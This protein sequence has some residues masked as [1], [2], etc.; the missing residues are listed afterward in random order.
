MPVVIAAKCHPPQFVTP[1]K[2]RRKPFILGVAPLSWSKY[3]AVRANPLFS[4]KDF[5]GAGW[6]MYYAF[7]Y[8]EDEFVDERQDEGAAARPGGRNAA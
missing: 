8:R 6:N 4:Y 5:A 7:T 2:Q 3:C 1:P